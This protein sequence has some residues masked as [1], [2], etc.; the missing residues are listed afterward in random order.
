VT[1][2]RQPRSGDSLV[3]WRLDRSL[4]DLIALVRRMEAKRREKLEVAKK[5][6]LPDA[7]AKLAEL[8]LTLASVLVSSR[9][10]PSTHRRA[11]LGFHVTTTSSGR[12]PTSW[13]RLIAILAIAY[14]FE[15]LSVL[16]LPG[17]DAQ[18]IGHLIPLPDSFIIP[19]PSQPIPYN[20]FPSDRSEDVLTQRNNNNRTGASYSPGLD[21]EAVRDFRK[22]GEMG[23]DGKV[24]AQP[25]YSHA[26]MVGDKIQPVLI[27]AV[28]ATNHVYAFSPNFPF[29][30]LW[31]ITL[32]A[33]MTMDIR[34]PGDPQPCNKQTFGIIATPVIDSDRNRVLISYRTSD[35]NKQHLAAIDLNHGEKV[36]D[37]VITPPSSRGPEWAGLHKNHPALLLADGV[38]YLAFSGFCEGTNDPP[39]RG[40][41][42]AFDSDTLSQVG[43]FEVVD[44][45]GHGGG[46]WQGSTGL[47]ADTRG[48]LYFATGN[49]IFPNRDIS[50]KQG[51]P[52]PFEEEKNLSSSVVRL[53]A[54]KVFP[55]QGHSNYR[56]VLSPVDYFTPYRK[57]MEDCFDLDLGSAG[58]VL[59]PS[60]PYLAAG[61]KEGVIY[62]LD[63]V[64]LGQWSHPDTAANFQSYRDRMQR[65]SPDNPKRD[66]VHQKFQ[67][68]ENRYTNGDFLLS[69]WR[70]W[71]H[72]HGTP[73]FARFSDAQAFLFVWPEKDTLK[74]FQ[75]DGNLFG[76]VPLVS[77]AVAAPFLVNGPGFNGMPGGMLSVNID[78]SG[79]GRGVV[80]ASMVFC[81]KEGSG[82][83]LACDKQQGSGILRAYDPLTMRQIWCNRPEAACGGNAENYDFSYFV[84][85]TIAAGRVF[86]ATWSNEV[87]VY[88][89]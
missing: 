52:P 37:V 32:G 19:V 24:T 8:D 59:I 17:A 14:T 41:I 71:P 72:I 44:E 75:W 34:S 54:E 50:C 2:S 58:V 83:S 80:F 15:C 46:I 43:E 33:P 16:C 30:K 27:V 76:D 12:L 18:E 23:V 25:L 56:L 9:Q 48:N 60:S 49:R 5:A 86:L 63:R 35:D 20:I 74:R 4:S 31:D 42:L 47:A 22:L 77:E 87:L 78:P 39:Y 1:G 55:S 69:D 40:S 84:P 88:G 45:H 11:P 21:Q 10:P 64:H 53:H 51:D 38:V 13:L 57:I 70:Q 81:E 85:P 67:A 68:S 7:C 36:Q 3:V 89:R 73:V 6:I 79:P 62:V 29:D 26:S 65:D 82:S 66:D 61:G 28:N